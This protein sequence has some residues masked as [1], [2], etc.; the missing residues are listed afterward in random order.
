[1]RAPLSTQG[2]PDPCTSC[3]SLPAVLWGT[4]ASGTSVLKPLHVTTTHRCPKF[5][6]R[7]FMFLPPK[8]MIPESHS[9]LS[10][11]RPVSL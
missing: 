8:A 7:H 4:P 3:S 11:S 5:H 2:H 10:Q 9:D 6:H 1:M